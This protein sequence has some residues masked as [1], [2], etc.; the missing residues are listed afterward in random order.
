MKKTKIELNPSTPVKIKKLVWNL[1]E[2]LE[3]VGVPVDGTARSME[4]MSKACLAVGGITKDFKDASDLEDHRYLRTRDIIEF[5]NKHYGEKLS[6]GSY[7]DVRRKDLRLL[8]EAGVVVSSSSAKSQ[9]VNNPS[10]GYALSTSFI[11]L[12]NAYNTDV[13]PEELKSYVDSQIFLKED[14]KRLRELEKI[15]VKLANG[16]ELRLSYGEHNVLQKAIIEQF[17]PRFGFEATVLYAGDTDDKFMHMDQDGLKDIHFFELSH[18]MLPDIVAYSKSKN[19]LYLIE[20]FHSTGEWNEIRLRTV[21]KKLQESGCTAVP[22][23][24][25]AFETKAMFRQ[26]AKDIAWETEVWLADNPDHLIHFNGGKFL[27]IHK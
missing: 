13:W 21:S 4:R 8:V 10:R 7:D 24:F 11:K 22:V 12:I 23:F 26:K 17:L 19:L 2:I 25:T 5:E 20:A 6:P 14:L 27:E 15:P 3:A 18:E 9:A 1:L 16:K